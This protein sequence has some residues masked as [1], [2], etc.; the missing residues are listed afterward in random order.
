MFGGLAHTQ[1]G[2]TG[3]TAEVTLYTAQEKTGEGKGPCS[4][5]VTYKHPGQVVDTYAEMRKQEQV[6]DDSFL[7]RYT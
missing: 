3:C 2:R 1:E 5:K 7:Y 4:A 6:E